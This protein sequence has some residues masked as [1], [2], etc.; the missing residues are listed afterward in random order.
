[1]GISRIL[2]VLIITFFITTPA[3]L[4]DTSRTVQV[5]QLEST[6][7]LLK[8]S[9][10]LNSFIQDLE[11][12][13]RAERAVQNAD[14][15]SSKLHPLLSGKI[16]SRIMLQVLNKCNDIMSRV[17]V[18]I[19]DFPQIVSKIQMN[20][21]FNSSTELL[22][23]GVFV[24]IALIAG[25][26]V[27]GVV[28]R[29]CHRLQSINQQ[30]HFNK[31]WLGYMFLF[32]NRISVPAGL[33]VVTIIL[34]VPFGKLSPGP[35]FMNL[36]VALLIY[37]V[38]SALLELLFSKKFPQLRIIASETAFSIS[39]FKGISSILTWALIFWLLFR[40]TRLAGWTSTSS[41][42]AAVYKVLLTVQLTYLSYRHRS[43]FLSFK[44]GDSTGLIRSVMIKSFKFLA[45]WLFVAVLLVCTI[46]TIASL[47]GNDAFYSYFLKG[48]LQSVLLIAGVL[49]GVLLIL[50]ILKHIDKIDQDPV[51]EKS[52]TDQL[53]VTNKK[54][55]DRTGFA[56][57]IILGLYLL[58][59][60]WGFDVYRIVR[61]DIPVISML[62]HILFITAGA[63]IGMQISQLLIKGF[64][65]K[66]QKQMQQSGT[67]EIEIKK[68]I[69][70]LGGIF[71]KI[72][73]VTIGVVAVIMVID[74]LG[75]DI[76][77]MLAGVGIVG[78]AVGFGAQNLVRD[79]IS[80]LFVIFENRIRVGDVAIINGTGG[81]VEQVNLRT[82]VLRSTDGTIHVFSN[83]AI[84][85]LSNMTHEYSYY[86]FDISID[87][88]EN[89]DRVIEILKNVGSS[90]TTDMKFNQSIL[91]PL[92]ILGLDKLG[93]SEV[94]I[95]ARIKTIP[96]KQWDI[97]REM[98]KRIKEAFDNEGIANPVTHQRISLDDNSRPVKVMLER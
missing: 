77:A 81:L 57:I 89:V 24:I 30:E 83:G 1:V 70:T 36:S 43:F 71:Q 80:G 28:K 12:V 73:V 59:R 44:S 64:L 38:A 60:I 56:L 55:I 63:F 87:Y 61:S 11:A 62:F 84:N 13:I 76:K 26:I 23:F 53:L 90:M 52:Y 20:S 47:S 32:F 88:K 72:S 8:D 19:T 35:L 85:S 97:G 94:V 78:I 96:I 65:T 9:V 42:A 66:A 93:V 39:A 21:V 37:S 86:V 75:F 82:I 17:Q 46:L 69:D 67:T 34:S 91:S 22:L 27:W 45:R 54:T 95:K 50:N 92:E 48:I 2:I 33:S 40:V 4:V 18:E 10:R 49:L 51:L 5:S 6:V 74:E 58:V 15:M 98:N 3:Q 16:D 7:A 79:V 14:T 68:R 25:V 29:V 31:R 41:L